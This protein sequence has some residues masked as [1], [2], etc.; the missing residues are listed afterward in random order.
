MQ[1][2]H[3]QYSIIQKHNIGG[4]ST[5]IK[6]YTHGTFIKIYRHWH[7]ELALNAPGFYYDKQNETCVVM[8]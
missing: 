1:L 6:I 3:K 4:R 7:F 2:I 5:F 8:N